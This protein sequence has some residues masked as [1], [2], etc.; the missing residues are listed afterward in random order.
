VDLVAGRLGQ[1]ALLVLLRGPRLGI[2]S[3]LLVGH[4]I[5]DFSP[6]YYDGSDG[7]ELDAS[8]NFE[9]KHPTY[10][11]DPLAWAKWFVEQHYGAEHVQDL[12][13]DHCI[14]SDD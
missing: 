4:R 10:K 3:V 12:D 11:Q 6:Y 2:R 13:W 8:R 5:L 9:F 1:L 7:G 14:V